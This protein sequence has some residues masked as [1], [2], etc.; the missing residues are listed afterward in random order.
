MGVEAN[1]DWVAELVDP[2][3]ASWITVGEFTPTSQT[4]VCA[5]NPG[6]EPREARVR[7]A[8]YGTSVSCVFTV[9]QPDMSSAFEEA[10]KVSIA[11]LLAMG[12]GK[13]A[14][15]VYVEGSVISDRATRN[16]PVAYSPG[17]PQRM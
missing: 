15:N 4:F 14:R 13:I 2:A 5:A 6:S 9:T 12:E 8:A 3:D 7:I 10:E 17:R 16:Y 1:I 11:E